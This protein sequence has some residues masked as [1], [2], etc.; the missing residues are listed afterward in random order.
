M[1]GLLHRSLRQEASGQTSKIKD[2]GRQLEA[3][4]RKQALLEA[5][6]ADLRG[7]LEEAAATHAELEVGAPAPLSTTKPFAFLPANC[8]GLIHP[9][10]ERK[11]VV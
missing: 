11:T 2:L 8:E 6:V 1:P 9:G 3:A 10:L 7:K 4:A 5:E